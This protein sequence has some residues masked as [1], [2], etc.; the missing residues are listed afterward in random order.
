[1]LCAD[2]LLSGAFVG[3]RLG[4][5]SV[6][7]WCVCRRMD[8]RGLEG[9]SSRGRVC[10]KAGMH[11]PLL[12]LTA[13]LTASAG[14]VFPSL[15]LRSAISL[16]L[17]LNISQAWLPSA[18]GPMGENRIWA[19]HW[20]HFQCLTSVCFICS[21]FDKYILSCVILEQFFYSFLVLFDPK[22]KSLFSSMQ[23]VVQHKGY[24]S[25]SLS[26]PAWEWAIANTCKASPAQLWCN[27]TGQAT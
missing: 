17:L 6:C 5:V 10:E 23:F 13:S 7:D 8:S 21:W 4:R 12:S 16:R 25:S 1:M 27:Y 22:N 20:L 26:L 18:P 19:T 9:H 24:S 2:V 14:D 3:Q 11:L 15:T